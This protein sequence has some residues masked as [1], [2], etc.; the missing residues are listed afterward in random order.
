VLPDDVRT[1]REQAFSTVTMNTLQVSHPLVPAPILDST[2][3]AIRD[4]RGGEVAGARRGLG[5]AR[6]G[7]V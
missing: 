6:R 3:V 2:P 1:L 7:G 4:D 5:L